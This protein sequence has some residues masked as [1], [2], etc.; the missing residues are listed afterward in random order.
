MWTRLQLGAA[1]VL[2]GLPVFA[3]VL[4][5]SSGREIVTKSGRPV[6]VQ[7]KDELFGG[8]NEETHLVPGPIFGYYIGLDLV[9]AVTAA[10]LGG[11]AVLWWV[12][13]RR[14]RHGRPVEG[15]GQHA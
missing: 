7:V 8:S 13:R 12:S 15:G 1:L 2:V 4:W 3:A 5:L 6:T 9:G 10:A 14:H 11:G